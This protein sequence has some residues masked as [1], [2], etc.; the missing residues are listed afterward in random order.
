M[1][2]HTSLLRVVNESEKVFVDKLQ[3]R[4]STNGVDVKFDF[5]DPSTESN[6]LCNTGKP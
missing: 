4:S 6:I 5:G 1:L 3:R 2:K